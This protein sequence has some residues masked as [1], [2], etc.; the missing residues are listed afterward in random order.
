[1]LGA[2]DSRLRPRVNPNENVTEREWF[3]QMIMLPSQ[4]LLLLVDWGD[5]TRLGRHPVPGLRPRRAGGGVCQ[6]GR[7]CPCV[8]DEGLW[9]GA[10]LLA[11][12]GWRRGGRPGG[13]GR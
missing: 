8:A 9:P 3:C 5:R 2:K 4:G 13:R 1:M 12:G 11:G 7:R 10:G 6:G